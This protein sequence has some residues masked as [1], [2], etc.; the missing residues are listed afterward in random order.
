[1]QSFQESAA[2]VDASLAAMEKSRA[3]MEAQVKTDRSSAE[4]KMYQLALA[5]MST[6]INTIDDD[7]PY[8]CRCHMKS[9]EELEEMKAAQEG[10]SFSESVTN[11]ATVSLFTGRCVHDEE[12]ECMALTNGASHFAA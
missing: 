2:R 6:V 12:Q 5:Q 4:E 10:S 11:A 1:M 3:K 8:S 9:E 7:Y